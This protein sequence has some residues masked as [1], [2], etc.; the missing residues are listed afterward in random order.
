MT[1]RVLCAVQHTRGV[2][3]ALWPQWPALPFFFSFPFLLTPF[4]SL[5]REKKLEIVDKPVL[6][7]E[8]ATFVEAGEATTTCELGTLWRPLVDL[9]RWDV[10]LA[11][12]TAQ[13]G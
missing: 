9:P 8:V 7:A 12:K 13:G 10:P 11:V 3:L 4:L 2:P 5:V 6:E 1:V